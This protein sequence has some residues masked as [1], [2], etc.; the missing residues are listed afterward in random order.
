MPVVVCPTCHN[1]FSA[2]PKPGVTHV[3][4]SL[5]NESV[6]LVLE[7]PPEEPPAPAQ[8]VRPQAAAPIPR[9][10][11]PPAAAPAPPPP[12][13]SPE[14]NVFDFDS[15]AEDE[16]EDDRPRRRRR[17]RDDD[18][19]DERPRRPYRRGE[20]NSSTTL[21]AIGVVVAIIVL[22]II[23]VLVKDRPR[24]GRALAEPIPRVEPARSGFGSELGPKR[25]PRLPE[26]PAVELWNPHFPEREA[27]KK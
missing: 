1:S 25:R 16:D 9:P 24:R 6:S 11:A 5:C 21:A 19:E 12:P 7:L 20:D 22:V 27:K 4:C 2:N 10:A 8:P 26:G 17:D 13:P 15:P 14:K 23:G 18:D 3:E